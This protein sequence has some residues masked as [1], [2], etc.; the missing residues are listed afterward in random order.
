MNNPAN[1]ATNAPANAV[2]QAATNAA[3][4][5]QTNVATNASSNLQPTAPPFVP[6]NVVAA[7]AATAATTEDPVHAAALR[8]TLR[9]ENER[10]NEAARV[11]NPKTWRPGIPQPGDNTFRAKV[12]EVYYP[13]V[14]LSPLWEEG[15]GEEEWKQLAVD[16]RVILK[17]WGFFHITGHKVDMKL[18]RE[19]LKGLTWF[20]D[21]P[22]EEKMVVHRTKSICLRGYQGFYDPVWS[23]SHRT[24]GSE[25]F[26]FGENIPHSKRP[27]QG[28]NQWPRDQEECA[29][30]K[31]SL[32]KWQV[33]MGNLAEQM[34]QL[35]AES[36]LFDN[37]MW[38]QHIYGNG[39]EII[40][41]SLIWHARSLT[42]LQ[43]SFSPTPSSTTDMALTNRR[44]P[45]IRSIVL[46]SCHF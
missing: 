9:A 37:D 19:L 25:S 44:R 16:L 45:T 18:S 13:I 43:R 22:I 14:D 33:Q 2:P 29:A 10:L 27:L 5:T 31:T 42:T 24:P 40:E 39:G 30:W 1:A 32:H 21:L 26:T 15:C 20:F 12:R 11:R 36:L 8:R 3:L 34:L 35:I 38:S 28:E 7:A 17:R 23:N 4:N 6:A 46:A 41:L